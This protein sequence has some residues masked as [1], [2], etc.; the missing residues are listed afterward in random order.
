LPV[1][2]IN[3]KAYAAII[4]IQIIQPDWE[5]NLGHDSYL[6]GSAYHGTNHQCHLDRQL[7]VIDCTLFAKPVVNA[8]SGGDPVTV[9]FG[10]AKDELY[11]I[12]QEQIELTYI[13]ILTEPTHMQK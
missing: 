12:M 7:L 1:Q 9:M 13:V 8:L 3:L 10:V 6:S 11:K 4:L 5:L 2:E